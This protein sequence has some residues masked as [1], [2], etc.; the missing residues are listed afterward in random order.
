MACYNCINRQCSKKQAW[1]D[2]S[3]RSIAE[4]Y[5]SAPQQ[6][7]IISAFREKWR[8]AGLAEERM[9]QRKGRAPVFVRLWNSLAARA[10]QARLIVSQQ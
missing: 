8:L 6:G 10:K 2:C 3:T 9:I 1:P 4:G 5:S 7:R